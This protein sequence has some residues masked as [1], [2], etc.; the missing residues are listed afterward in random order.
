LCQLAAKAGLYPV[1]VIDNG[2]RFFFE[3][4]KYRFFPNYARNQQWRL[5]DTLIALI[6]QFVAEQALG[7]V[8]ACVLLVCRKYV[9]SYCRRASDAA[10][11]HGPVRRDH[12]VFQL[13]DLPADKI[14]STRLRL[15]ND[16]IS[17]FDG[18][19]TNATMFRERFESL[20]E[21]LSS[22]EH[23][24][25]KDTLLGTIW[26]LAHQGHRSFLN[27]LSALPV[28]V[29]RDSHLVERLFDSPHVLLRLYMSNMYKRYTEDQGHFPNLFLN[30]CVVATHQDFDKA[31]LPHQHT[32]WLRYLILRFVAASPDGTC[33]SEKVVDFFVRRLGYEEHLVR[34]SL[35][36][37][38]DP[39]CSSCLDIVMPDRIKR[40]EEVLRISRRG[41]I[42]VT[43]RGGRE[44][45]CFSFDYLQ[46]ITDDYLL[47]MPK[48]VAGDIFVD[49]G[50][51]HTLKDG[52]EYARGSRNV[53]GKKIPAVIRFFM[54]LE[55]SFKAEMFHREAENA[56]SQIAPDFTAIGAKLVQSIEAVVARF[57]DMGALAQIA[58]PRSVWNDQALRSTIDKQIV[59]YYASPVPVAV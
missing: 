44:P 17:Q 6:D 30:D 37:L 9:Y 5:D 8:A 15:I 41:S 7:K 2:D 14:V 32:Y 50:L 29:R 24:S 33:H 25:K 16:C 26:E 23:Q 13:L 39:N 55:S 58:A 46:L 54:V 12:R 19:Y 20:R 3:N 21:R 40:N 47:A 51:G 45:L 59:E 42:L 10:D 52:H 57:D 36:F 1:F 49:A 4:A 53:L 35:G 18:A 22:W 48:S 56:V 28:D 11:P 43:E 31:H 34:I 27:F 38:S